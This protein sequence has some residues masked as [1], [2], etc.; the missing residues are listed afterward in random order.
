MQPRHQKLHNQAQKN[1]RMHLSPL[2]SQVAAS[3]AKDSFIRMHPNIPKLHT[4]AAKKQ[5][6]YLSNE[7][8]QSSLQAD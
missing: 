4:Y 6:S 8:A 3:R 7:G 5:E 1:R 2:A